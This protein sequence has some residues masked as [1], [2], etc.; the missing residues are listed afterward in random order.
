M[1]YGV[2]IPYLLRPAA[3]YVGKIFKGT[4]PGEIPLE[5]SKQFK[6]IVNLQTAKKIGL[7]IPQWTLTKADRVIK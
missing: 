6:F 4:K 2:Y 7:T 3:T 5:Q 1:S